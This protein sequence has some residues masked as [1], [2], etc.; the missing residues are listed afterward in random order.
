MT[1]EQRVEILE[2]QMATLMSSKPTKS[3]A[4]KADDEPKKKR[5][6]SGYLIFSNATRDEVKV[7]L[8]DG[9]E[10]PKPQAVTVELA[11]LWKALEQDEREEWNTKAK[12]MKSDS[13]DDEPAEKA[14]VEP[15]KKRGTNGYLLFSNA[16]RDEVKVSLVDGDEKPKPQAITTELARLWKALEQ[17]EREEWNTK[18]KAINGASE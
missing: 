13:S 5:A 1:L 6:P 11:R 9:E 17:D 14:V 15:K 3:K 12:A 10:K 7:S 2:K 4:K 16:T 8:A 18:A